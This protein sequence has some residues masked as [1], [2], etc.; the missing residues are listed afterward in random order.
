ML[1]VTTT[2]STNLALGKLAT[3]SSFQAGN[4]V[5]NANDG[6]TTTR[7]AA[8]DAT[9]P[10][11]WEVD[12]GASKTLT[13]VDINWYAN[14]TRSSKY[15]IQTSPDNA[16]WTTMVNKSTNTTVGPTSDSFSATA[17]YVRVN[18]SAVSS[19]FVS[20][21]EIGVYGH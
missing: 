1:T 14:A 9:V 19:G 15:M 13:R 12:L 2:T 7:W 11:W 16:T 10:Q 6:S 18:I 17:R 3:A 8:S 5:A 20:A 4:V 21:Y